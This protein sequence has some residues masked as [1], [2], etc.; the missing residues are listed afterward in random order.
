MSNNKNDFKKGDLVIFKSDDYLDLFLT[1]NASSVFVYASGLNIL[2]V[3][4]LHL[5]YFRNDKESFE[6]CNILVL[7]Y[8]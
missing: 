1:D 8:E 6:G 3:E 5:Y 2:R 7:S 4:D